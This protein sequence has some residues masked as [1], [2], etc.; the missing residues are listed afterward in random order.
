[1]ER[2]WETPAT[3]VV[4]R[5][6]RP[7][8]PRGSLACHGAGM[9]TTTAPAALSLAVA[10]V[11]DRAL[12]RNSSIFTT[13]RVWT[14]DLL[15]ELQRRTDRQV[16][17]TGT[18]FA[19]RWVTVLRRADDDLRL[20]A[21]EVLA[22]HLLFPT[23]IGAARK[24]DLVGGTLAGLRPPGGLP[25]AFDTAFA[26]GV[27]PTGV[28]FKTLRLSQLRY[29]CA[30]A[31]AFKALRPVGRRAVLADPDACR[32]LAWSVPARG[33]VAQREALLHLLH[34]DAFEPLTSPGLKARIAD[35]LGDLV[36]A[37]AADVD[38]SLRAA[39]AALTARHGAGFSFLDPRIAALWQPGYADRRPPG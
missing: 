7:R 20:L 16:D 11:I 1:M 3:A 32:R 8:A 34:P 5:R 30:V 13:R 17:A 33:G 15:T 26:T 39:R 23:D 9:P 21:A 36:P 27:A 22:V 25:H 35:G 28:A 10:R 6:E 4:H 2:L 12:A 38:Q 24:R 18:T 19:Q 29:L 14:A 37:A 31:A